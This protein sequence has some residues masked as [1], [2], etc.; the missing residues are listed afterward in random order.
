MKRQN[1]FPTVRSAE[2]E[3]LSNFAD[4]VTAPATALGFDAA[5]IT[6]VVKDARFC[7][8][9]SGLWL[10]QVRAFS[11]ACTAAVEDVY[12]GTTPGAY[13]LPPFVAPTLP[14]G[15]VPVPAGA[16]GRI[17]R[18][19]A[20]FKNKPGYTLAM[21]QD[22]NLI[23]PTETLPELP[24]FTLLVETGSGCECVRIRFKKYGRL[25]VVV[26]CRRNG[27]A[28]EALGIDTESPYLDERPLL[29]A[30]APEVREYRL[31][32]WDGAPTGDYTPVQRV[33]VGP[34]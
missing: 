23:G 12:Y 15:V 29:V 2:P 24:E 22:L 34:V 9:V 26:E 17:F 31:R 20:D 8:Y 21:G 14:A 5:V 27:G 28:W 19:V 16:L 30:G 4:K 18:F 11:P 25:G 33:T 32:F 3:W 6:D 1:Y 13:V 7:A 10:T